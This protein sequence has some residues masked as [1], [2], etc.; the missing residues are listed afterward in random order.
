MP[1]AQLTLPDAAFWNAVYTAK[2]RAWDLSEQRSR[3]DAKA[4][5]FAHKR[6]RSG[7][8][9]QLIERLGLEPGDTVF[10]MGCGSGTLSLPLAQAGHQVVSVD[11]SGGMLGELCALAQEEGVPCTRFDGAGAP[12]DAPRIRTFQR[13][14]QDSWDDLPVADVAVSSRSLITNDLEDAIGKLEAHARKRVAVTVSCGE[15]P[16]CDLRMREVIGRPV[17]YVRLRGKYLAVLNFLLATGRMPT[18]AVIEHGHRWHAPTREALV[19]AAVSSVE[20]EN[21]EERAL[22]TAFVDE[23]LVDDPGSGEVTLDYQQRVRWAYVEWPVER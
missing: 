16:M 3:W 23:R 17:D 13:A 5:S 11:F 12:V 20:V 8:I 15:T 1:D 14:W 18:T 7:Y 22:L 19:E 9:D 2:E 6:S 10:D 4:P 21:D